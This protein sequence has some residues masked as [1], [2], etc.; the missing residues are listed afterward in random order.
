MM[1]GQEPFP[2]FPILLVPEIPLITKHLV[3]HLLTVTAKALL[4]YY[5]DVKQLHPSFK[6]KINPALEEE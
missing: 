3:L 4:P 2:T 6:R 1:P 5:Y